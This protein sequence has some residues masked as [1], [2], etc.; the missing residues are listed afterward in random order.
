MEAVQT[1]ILDYAFLVA[2]VLY[3]IKII[4]NNQSAGCATASV[5][6]STRSENSRSSR[7]HYRNYLLVILISTV[8]AVRAR[9]GDRTRCGLISLPNRKPNRSV[10][11]TS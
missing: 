10:D 11:M 7:R 1:E 9:V 8:F 4:L 2:N 3:L 5:D 6:S